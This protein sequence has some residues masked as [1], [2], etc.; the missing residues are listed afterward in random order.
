MWRERISAAAALEKVSTKMED[1]KTSS[2]LIRYWILFT[3]TKVLPLPGPAM[4]AQGPAPWQMAVSCAGFDFL[5]ES[6]LTGAFFNEF[7]F[8]VFDLH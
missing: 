8:S 6:P 2:D 1:G 3:R 7:F 4:T 5:S